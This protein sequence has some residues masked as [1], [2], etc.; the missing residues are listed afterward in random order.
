[1]LLSYVL[2][3]FLLDLKQFNLLF[4]Q[5][6]LLIPLCPFLF[7][8]QKVKLRFIALIL[9]GLWVKLGTRCNLPLLKVLS[10]VGFHLTEIEFL[11]FLL[12]ARQDLRA[13]L[14]NLLLLLFELRGHQLKQRFLGQS[15]FLLQK[16]FY[17]CVLF[18]QL[19][20]VLVHAL[21]CL[22]TSQVS[23]LLL[24]FLIN[25]K[26]HPL[27][28]L[29]VFFNQLH[30]KRSELKPFQSLLALFFVNSKLCLFD[31]FYIFQFRFWGWWGL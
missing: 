9:R 30:L 3:I 4:L 29:L 12:D 7:H 21:L 26:H 14:F 6:W 23:K 8:R 16:W 25:W 22:S 24:I 19:N 5:S 20:S 13:L 31:Y 17:L 1:M 11:H 27:P 18:L 15:L 28:L 10:L 2:F